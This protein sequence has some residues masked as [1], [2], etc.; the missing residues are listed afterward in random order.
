MTHEP[1]DALAHETFQQIR[2]E[3]GVS[4]GVR[5]VDGLAH[6][7]QER[8]SPE[9]AVVGGGSGEVEH[10]EG[11]VEGITLGMEAG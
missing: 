7:V 1:H 5:V 9:L 6:V 11:V 2:A 10:L 4:F 3:L 8:R